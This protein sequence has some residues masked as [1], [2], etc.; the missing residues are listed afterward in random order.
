[1]KMSI[2]SLF[3]NLSFMLILLAILLFFI[4]LVQMDR[5]ASFSK[6]ANLQEQ[7]SLVNKIYDL[8]R[9]DLD[10]SVIQARGMAAQLKT[11]TLT[12]DSFSSYDIFGMILG[13]SS[14]FQ[15]DVKNLLQLEDEY[16]KRINIYYENSNESLAEKLQQ[17]DTAKKALI[18]MLD[19]MTIKNISYDKQKFALSQWLVYL[20]F[21]ISLFIAIM[22]SK[23]LK[24]VYDDIKSLFAIGFER[25]SDK[26]I[27]KEVDAIKIRMVR[28]PTTTENPNMVDPVTGIKNSKGM[29]QSY[30]EKKTMKESGFTAVC[31]LEVDNFKQY[32]KELPKELTQAMLKKIAF[33][34]SLY[35]QPT[36]VIAR[37]DLDQF[38]VIL[39]RDNKDKALNDCDSMRKSIEE[40]VFKNPQGGKIPF[41]LS[42]GFIIKQGNK[43]LEDSISYAKE[44]LQTAK[45]KDGNRIA[46]IHD[47]AEKF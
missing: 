9:A 20:T 25:P 28:K 37:I 18:V 3:K 35:E 7:K 31:V 33:I 11:D 21:L 5:Y 41:T 46:Q 23:K 27:T 43:S 38:A 14:E 1:M 42:G 16:I 8:G 22:Y 45:E 34:I 4:S 36:D 13:Q 15:A 40:A 29:I 19:S 12:L 32:N 2:E 17:L 30:S 6:V 24:I 26:I 10:Y 47:H 44:V 39:Q